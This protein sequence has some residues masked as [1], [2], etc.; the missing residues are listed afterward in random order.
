MP[1]RRSMPPDRTDVSSR[2]SL[3]F[4][5]RPA[6]IYSFRRG[7]AP[8]SN[9]QIVVQLFHVRVQFRID[10]TFDDSPVFHDE[11]AIGDGRC[12][13]EILL[14][15]ENGEAL[16]L[17][18]PNGAADLLDDDRRE[19]FGRLV[20]Q[21]QPRAGA[22]DAADGEHLLLAPRQLAALARAQALLEVGKQREDA[23]EPETARLHHRREQQ[24][25]LDAQ[26]GENPALLRTERDAGMGDLVRGAADELASL[27]AHRS[28]AMSNDPHDR[29][30]G[31]GLAGAVA[32]EQR[33][34]LAA[35]HVEA[36]AV[37]HMRLAVPCLQTFDTEKRGLRHGPPPDRLRALPD[38]RKPYRSRP[39]RG[40]VRA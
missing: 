19:A 20:E 37:E 10:E 12:E 28:G 2:S 40:S 27:E 29:L 7:P 35:A 6:P 13:A 39:R 8:C 26:R 36:H 25:L 15:Q 30:E 21:E 38:W 5:R 23:I 11:I 34:H 18:S 16:L 22:Q 9:S 32:A 17:E 4:R 24:V 14:D 3:C 31:G 1:A 33:H